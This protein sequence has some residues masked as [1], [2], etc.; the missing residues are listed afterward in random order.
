MGAPP[1]VDVLLRW[2]TGPAP[3]RRRSTWRCSVARAFPRVG[4]KL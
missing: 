1:S 3:A 2:R 4:L